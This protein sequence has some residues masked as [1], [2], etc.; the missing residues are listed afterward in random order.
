MKKLAFASLLTLALTFSCKENKKAETTDA[1]TKEV[2]TKSGYQLVNDSVKV[3]F[4]AYKTTEKK[5]VGGS[6]TEINIKNSVQGDTPLAALNGI[7]F[8]IPVSS[9]FTNDATG[10]RDPKIKE[11]F[12]GV[13]K[14]TE[15]I[16]GKL[17]VS[18]EALSMEIT[19]NGETNSI[20][21]TLEQVDGHNYKVSG[22]MEMGDWNALEAVAS[23][24][25]ACEVLH[26]GPDGVSKTWSDVAVHANISFE[27]H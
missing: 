13:M 8:G 23:I 21:M 10:T 19:L 4:T 1:D 14:N 2:V 7:E 6:F 16:S 3:G 22:T 12:F 20:P 26:T 17:S 5:P 25:K 11:F 15:L 18:G 24:N 9:L 27:K